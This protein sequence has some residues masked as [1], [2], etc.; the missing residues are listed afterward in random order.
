[1]NR[2]NVNSAATSLNASAF[3]VI[4]IALT[5][6]NSTTRV[7]AYGQYSLGLAA[8]L[9]NTG[10]L[11]FVRVDYR[12]GS[13]I[14]GVTGNAGL[15]YQ[16]TP[17]TIAAII[18][19]KAPVKALGTVIRP[20]NW[21]VSTSAASLAWTTA[22]PTSGLSAPVVSATTRACSA[23]LAASSSVTTTRPRTTGCSAWKAT[24]VPPTCRGPGLAP[25]A[26]S[27]PP[28]S[29]ARISSNWMAT[30]AG[31]IGYSWGRTL[32]YG[33]AGGAVADDTVKVS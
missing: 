16:F 5:G 17:E 29:S 14:D 26:F 32:F 8:E 22:A 9:A 28:R 13:N 24:S 10:W 1:M 4:P 19:T 7:G 21:T 30:V 33:K 2:G 3:G 11:G 25:P 27:L 18:P 12:N 31:R 23:A 6:T 15:R 20:T